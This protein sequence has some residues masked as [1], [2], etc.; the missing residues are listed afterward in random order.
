MAVGIYTS[1]ADYVSALHEFDTAANAAPF[2]SVA[3]FLSSVYFPESALVRFFR[4]HEREDEIVGNLLA[5]QNHVRASESERR[6]I[7]EA[8]ALRDLIVRGEPHEQE[9]SYHISPR[10]LF[11]TLRA[12]VEVIESDR[13]VEVGITSEI[14]PMVFCINREEVLIDVRVNHPYQTIQGM[15]ISD[16]ALARDAFVVEFER[17][18]NAKNTLTDQREILARI[19]GSLSD[20][21]SGDPLAAE[22]WD[23]CIPLRGN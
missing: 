21:E 2:L 1:N 8:R 12:L 16:D 5:R 23:S 3:S 6:E 7:Y 14:V 4:G 13:P 19:R 17:L 10:E 15:R 9:T 18:W 20:W 22:H 11:T